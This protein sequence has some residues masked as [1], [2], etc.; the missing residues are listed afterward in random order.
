MADAAPLPSLSSL[1]R[2][3]LGYSSQRWALSSFTALCL[4]VWLLLREARQCPLSF[5]MSNMVIWLS[6]M[7][8]RLVSGALLRTAAWCS[9]VETLPPDRQPAGVTAPLRMENLLLLLSITWSTI[10]FL[11]VYQAAIQSRRA[12]LCG[13]DALLTYCIALLSCNYAAFALPALMALTLRC[14]AGRAARVLFPPA[15]VHLLQRLAAAGVFSAP[16]PPASESQIRALPEERFRKARF[17]VG[18]ADC[19]M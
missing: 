15:L 19:V 7:T 2:R 11:Y 1:L 17:P 3:N 14:A 12:G 10:G 9:W 4:S 8:A 5:G 13:D 16:P 18:P 6:V